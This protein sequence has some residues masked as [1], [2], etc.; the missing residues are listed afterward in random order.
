MGFSGMGDPIYNALTG[1]D[2]GAPTSTTSEIFELDRYVNVPR[3]R[4]QIRNWEF[5]STIFDDNN[6]QSI[7]ENL[8]D[9]SLLAYM[10]IGPDDDVAKGNEFFI[11]TANFTLDEDGKRLIYDSIRLVT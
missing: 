9:E 5:A 10:G 7:E 8:E 2:L 11:N 1:A 6:Y 3:Y 4:D